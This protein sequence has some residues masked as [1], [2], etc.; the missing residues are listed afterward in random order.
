MVLTQTLNAIAPLLSPWSLM[1]LAALMLQGCGE[2]EQG[3][4]E[5]NEQEQQTVNAYTRTQAPACIGR[6]QMDMPRQLVLSYSTLTVNEARISAKLTTQQM[7]KQFI[8]ERRNELLN[9][10]PG[11]EKDQPYLKHVYTPSPEIVIFD[12]NNAPHIPDALR[13]LEGYR[14][15]GL[16]MFR[17]LLKARDIEDNR[18]T[19]DRAYVETNKPDRLKQ[20]EHLLQNLHPRK[21][22][23]IPDTPGLCFEGGFLAGGADDPIPGAALPFREEAVAMTFVDRHHQDVHIHFNTNSTIRTEDTLLDRMGQAESVMKAKRDDNFAVLRKGKLELQGI[24]QSE[25]WL[26]IITTDEDVRGHHF[27][28]EA[29]SQR[30]ST[31]EP[32]ISVTF[33]NGEFSLGAYSHPTLSKASLTDAEAVG[34]WDAITRSFQARPNAF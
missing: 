33:R 34:L 3:V 1:V 28:I 20:V 31:R 7:F 13:T 14:R 12:R 22:H 30:G 27:I 23:E 16:T 29:N 15:I 24:E 4:P 10:E 8:R 6:F 17:V 11:D 9:T 32:R 18:Y 25:E 21:A 19:K 5:M 26:G 2:W